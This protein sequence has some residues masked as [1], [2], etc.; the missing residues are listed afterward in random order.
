M[1]NV[2]LSG[3]NPLDNSGSREGQWKDFWRPL[4]SSAESQQDSSLSDTRTAA[5]T[6]ARSSER[7]GVSI[8]EPPSLQMYPS[9]PSSVSMPTY[10][11][12]LRG[13]RLT[14]LSDAE[15]ETAEMAFPSEYLNLERHEVRFLAFEMAS[16][17][18][19]S[20]KFHLQYETDGIRYM[21]NGSGDTFGMPYIEERV[22]VFAA[23]E[24]ALEH[25]LRLEERRRQRR[26]AKRARKMEE[27]LKK[28]KRDV[29]E[30]FAQLVAAVTNLLNEDRQKNH[31]VQVRISVRII[32][33]QGSTPAKEI[34]VSTD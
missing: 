8:R 18:E 33:P 32:G 17:T 19:I 7:H 4:V 22:S 5:S 1:L 6:D 16:S 25:Q 23:P 11:S 14:H 12:D 31:G 2:P 9:L 20:L 26:L 3:Q 27:A 10:P 13:E 24:K 15:W 28:S 30:T 21:E 29:I 34:T